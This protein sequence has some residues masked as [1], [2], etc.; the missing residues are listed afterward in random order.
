VAETVLH[1]HILILA[2][3]RATRHPGLCPRGRGAGAHDHGQR[4][5]SRHPRALEPRTIGGERQRTMRRAR[6]AVVIV[7]LTLS[8]AG[9]AVGAAES[10]ATETAVAWQGWGDAAFAR[11]VREHRL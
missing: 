8:G 10:R 2:V 11:A 7:A 4:W 6:Q 5:P 9:S 3:L 1:G